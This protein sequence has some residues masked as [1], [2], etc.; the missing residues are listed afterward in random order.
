MANL[1]ADYKEE[2]VRAFVN[3]L[4]YGKKEGKPAEENAQPAGKGKNKT[5]AEEKEERAS[6]G[7]FFDQF[8][9]KVGSNRP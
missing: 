2:D 9:K 4:E 8:L 6:V 1:L 7:V 5:D 3:I